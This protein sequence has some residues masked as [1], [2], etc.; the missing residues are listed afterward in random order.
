LEFCSNLGLG[1][2]VDQRRT[3]RWF[4]ELIL[5]NHT[6]GWSEYFTQNIKVSQIINQ[7]NE[8]YGSTAP[9][10]VA[11][12]SVVSLK[13]HQYGGGLLHSHPHLYP[14]TMVQQQQI[15]AYLHKD[16]NN[17]W[18][19]KPAKDLAARPPKAPVMLR[20]GD[21]IRLEHVLTRRNLHSHAHPAPV[22]VG[23]Q[24]VAGVVF[25]LCSRLVTG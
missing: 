12:G 24:Q 16:Q 2:F 4:H 1:Q 20:N 19:V 9:A 5:P 11:Y 8:L 25:F 13:N 10:E 21:T 18:L 17:H 22:T 15:T 7:G 6:A 3:W 14:D 23:M